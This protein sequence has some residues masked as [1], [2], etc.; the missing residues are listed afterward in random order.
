MLRLPIPFIGPV[1]FSGQLLEMEAFAIADTRFVPA[2]FVK[3][4]P[5]DLDET[6]NSHAILLKM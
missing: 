2:I 3:E 6:W 1:R 5:E 4:I